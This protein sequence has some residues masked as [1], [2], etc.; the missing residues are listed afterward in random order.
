VRSYAKNS[1]GVGYGN[2]LSFQTLPSCGQFTVNH[3]AGDVA[4]VNKTVTYNTVKNI[5]G[6]LGKCWTVQNLGADHM[7]NTVNDA[8]E[9]S[10]GWY[11]RFDRKQGYKQDGTNPPP[12]WNN[13]MSYGSDWLPDNDPCRIEMGNPWRVPTQ[14]EWNNVSTAGGWSNWNGP[15][16]SGLSL[17]SAGYIEGYYNN[18]NSRGT[19]GHYWSSTNYDYYYYGWALT[20]NSNSSYIYNSGYKAYGFSIRCIKDTCSS[21]NLTGV[22]ISPSNDTVCFGSDVTFTATPVNGGSSPI[23][24]WKVNGG[25]AGDNSPTFSYIPVNGN[26]V[27]CE[28]TSSSICTINPVTSNS[29]TL[30][31]LSQIPSPNTG[32]HP[33]TPTEITWN[34]YMVAEATGYKW[35]TSD[36]YSTAIDIGN[37][38]SYTETGL[39]PTTYY[40]RYIWAYNNCGYSIANSMGAQTTAFSIGL[41]YGGG[42]IF[43]IDATG[44][45]GL[46]AATTDQTP[47]QWGCYGTNIGGTSIEIGTGQANTLAIVN[48]CNSAG[49]AAQLCNDLVQNGYSDWYLPSLNE[50]NL[51]FQ[52]RYAIGGFQSDF[53]W[54]SSEFN[55]N[56]AWNH[57]FSIGNQYNFNKSYGTLRIRA[58]RSF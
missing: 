3:I 11:W 57:D 39:N 13:N 50:L 5:P 33:T 42:V 20:F 34:W 41:N 45:H 16:T 7:A 36:D 12:Y 8:T 52:Q 4:P 31:V 46:I 48:G 23:Y 9:A 6:E 53:Y 25:N 37:N 47:T 29:V 38:F 28:F 35:N 17:H 22:S 21:Y 40:T 19:S 43:Y 2:Q 58:I 44:Q 54:S 15:W 32:S 30:T 49:I 24:Q 55:A 18:L 26:V 27:T 51:M 14:T 10:A 1:I 56:N